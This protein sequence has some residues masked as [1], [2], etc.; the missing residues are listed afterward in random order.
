[1]TIRNEEITIKHISS[2]ETHSVRKIV[3][4]PNQD[5]KSVI[6]EGDDLDDTVHF[7]LYVSE[8]LLSVASIYKR[9]LKDN[10]SNGW[11]LR[12]MATLPEHQGKGLGSRLLQ[13]CIDHVKESKGD[14]IWCNARKSAVNYYRKFG[15]EVISD[16]F[17]IANIGPHY[18]MI[19]DI[20]EK[21]IVEILDRVI[22]DSQILSSI[23]P[24]IEGAK[25][26]TVAT[27]TK[28]VSLSLF[29][30]KL[31]KQINLCRIFV[32]R[33]NTASKVERHINSFQ[34][35]VT[36]L[37][38]GDTKILNNNVWVSNVRTADGKTIKDRW[39]SVPENTW[40]QPI[41]KK[42]DWVT[43][44]FHTARESEIIDEYQES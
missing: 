9:L 29:K 33:A 19:F 20:K 10:N 8:K 28:N 4:R 18:V 27:V 16:E 26:E 35:T 13:A 43:V 31:P 39:L 15:F 37:G 34:R 12:A 2:F 3:L 14:Y 30:K 42:E 1:M 36:I 22:K 6:F 11:Q 23:T 32:L 21:S 25:N 40:H 44:T 5:D 41:S 24:L 38:S 7:G 17:E